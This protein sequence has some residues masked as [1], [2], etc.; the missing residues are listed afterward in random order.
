[1][2]TASNTPPPDMTVRQTAQYTY[3]M[4][5]SLRGIAMKQEQIKLAERIADAAEEAFRLANHP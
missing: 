2:R 1:M 3:D 5:I 4:L